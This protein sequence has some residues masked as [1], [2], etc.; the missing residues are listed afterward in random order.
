MKNFLPPV[1]KP[2]QIKL[3]WRIGLIIAACALTVLLGTAAVIQGLSVKNEGPD[4]AGTQQRPIAESLAGTKP[5]ATTAVVLETTAQVTAA[6]ESATSQANSDA[7]IASDS[8]KDTTAAQAT[9]KPT[10]PIPPANAD[11]INILLVG[12]DARVGL[13]GARSD[14]MILI[15]YNKEK[16]SFKLTSFM[17]DT[18]VPIEGHGWDRLNAAFAYGGVDLTIDTL[19]RNFNLAIKNY[20]TIRFEQFVAIVD[21]LGGIPVNLYQKEI[22]YINVEVRDTQ[23]DRTPGV[24]LLNGAQTLSHCR[25]RHVGNGDF[26]RTQRQRTVI[27]AIL[28]KLQQQRDPA[29]I[30][31]LVS[32]AMANAKTDLTADKLLTLTLD[33]LNAD[34][35]SFDDTRIP[36][37]GTWENA[38]KSG[39]SVIAV[40]FD[41][42]RKKLSQFLDG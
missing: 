36:F 35:L 27:K 22:D 17:R 3:T 7:T 38:T 32:F 40:D 18:W 25:D 41:A 19:N 37:D 12:S 30:T 33:V 11:G 5:E 34:N 6:D 42:N 31:R 26:E 13:G 14:S 29:T 4:L 23:L 21:Q 2:S 9:P 16:N 10:Q 15:A 8:S 1:I 20:V 28:Q 24:K 39:K